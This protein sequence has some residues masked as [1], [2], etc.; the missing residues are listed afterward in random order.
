MNVN[1]NYIA[2]KRCIL[3]DF[4]FDIEW[5]DEQIRPIFVDVYDKVI[6]EHSHIKN[7][8]YS[9]D[10]GGLV[11]LVYLDHY[12]IVAYRFSRK[13][14][15]KGFDKL[16]DAVYYSLRVRCSLDLFY[17]V[18]L[19][20]F[21]MPAHAIGTCMDAHAKY[22]KLFKIYNGCHIGPFSIIGLEPKDWIHPV[23]GD[24]VT[25]LSGSRVYGKS[26]IGNNVIL[27][28]NTVVINEIIPD[29]CIVSGTSPSLY[30]KRLEVINPL[31]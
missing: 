24:N 19:G 11:N 30:F 5:N 31:K 16:A 12:A 22:G 3:S 20:P 23:F 28:V 9:N 27:S 4:P 2:L 13:L 8:Y 10:E 25:M 1:N 21:F 14:W 15:L 7:S 26:I 6:E 17:K 18:D 29:N